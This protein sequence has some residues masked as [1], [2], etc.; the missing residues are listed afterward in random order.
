MCHCFESLADLPAE[1]RAE[2]LA[3]HDVDE[4]RMED[5]VEELVTLGV[6]A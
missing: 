4:L 3:E 1:E 5:P 6:D 2:V